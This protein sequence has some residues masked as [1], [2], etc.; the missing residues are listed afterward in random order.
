M[1]PYFHNLRPNL[2]IVMSNQDIFF[3]S[4]SYICL[5]LTLALRWRVKVTA[6]KVEFHYPISDTFSITRD[7]NF[8]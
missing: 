1:M 7:D 6:C 3:L 2:N 4:F 8:F 5:A